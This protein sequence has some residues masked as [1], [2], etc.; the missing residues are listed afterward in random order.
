MPAQVLIAEP[1][2]LQQQYDIYFFVR[3]LIA[4]VTVLKSHYYEA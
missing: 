1:M 3:E 4:L 2:L